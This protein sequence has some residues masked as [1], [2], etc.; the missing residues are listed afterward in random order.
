[1]TTIQQQIDNIKKEYIEAKTI[2]DVVEI[3]KKTIIVIDDMNKERETKEKEQDEIIIQD[4]LKLTNKKKALSFLVKNVINK[5]LYEKIIKKYSITEEDIENTKKLYQTTPISD[6][7][8]KEEG[9]LSL[10]EMAK[11]LNEMGDDEFEIY[12]DLQKGRSSETLI[13]KTVI[14]N[15]I[16]K[17]ERAVTIQMTFQQ[18]FTSLEVKKMNLS[19]SQIN[20]KVSKN[21]ILK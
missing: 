20:T 9:T 10:E 2:E 19:V 1:M 15:L 12:L 18:T 17:K 8:E 5:T 7:T 21:A 6:E 4:I 13:C 11:K 16:E 14:N 3:L